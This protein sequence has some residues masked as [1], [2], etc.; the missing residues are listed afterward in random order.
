[1]SCL[2]GLTL[3]RKKAFGHLGQKLRLMRFIEAFLVSSA[4]RQ[5]PTVGVA[6]VGRA[7]GG[8]DLSGRFC[9]TF[10]HFKWI[11]YHRFPRALVSPSLF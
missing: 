10:C 6:S 8:Y 5:A 2:I 9:E 1:M 4:E 11:G 7:C 3:R